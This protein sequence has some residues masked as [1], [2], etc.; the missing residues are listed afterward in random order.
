[1]QQ[2]TIIG[3]SNTRGHAL[4]YGEETKIR[5][6]AETCQSKGIYMYF[7]PLF[8]ETTGGWSDQA[9]TN[10]S[11]IGHFLGQRLGR[12]ESEA[13]RHLFQRLAITLWRGITRVY[14]SIV[15]QP[16]HHRLQLMD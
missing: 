6:H 9:I 11:E 13:I 4:R 14:G 12:S 15:R 3:A 5:V 16:S 8:V 7:V 1:M 10:I 2:K